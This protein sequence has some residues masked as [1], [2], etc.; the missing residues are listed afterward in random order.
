MDQIM[1]TTQTREEGRRL[2][3][4]L[5]QAFESGRA[6]FTKNDYKEAQLRSDFL[7]PFLKALGWDVENEAHASQFF[8]TVLQEESID[9]EEG[10]GDTRKKNPDY[11]LRVN[12]KRELFLE[13]KKARIDILTAKSPAFQTRRYGWSAGLRASVLTNFDQLV[14]YD[15]NYRPDAA[16]GAQV[17]RYQTF[18][19]TEYGDRF[20]EI[21]DILSYEAVTA[22][23]ITKVFEATDHERIGFDEFFLR[24]IQGWRHQLAQNILSNN[25]GLSTLQLN[26]LVQSLI[27]RIVFL[28]IC[29][30]REIEERDVL[31]NITSYEELKALF[32][33]SDKRYNSGLFDFVEDKISLGITIS[34]ETL[35]DIF[36]QLYFPNSP[37]DFAVVDSSILSQIYERFLSQKI[38]ILPEQGMVEIID[39]EQVVASN[40]VVPTP[41]FIVDEIV[42]TT[43]TPLVEGKSLEELRSLKIADICCG[44]GTF[45]IGAYN[46]LLRAYAHAA[47]EGGIND[48]AV[49]REDQF[50]TRHLTLN[51]KREIVLRNLWGVDF[52]RYAVEVARFSLLLK[53]LEDEEAASVDHFIATSKNKALPSLS[54]NIKSGNSLVGS[55]YYAF[56][57]RVLTD[58]ALLFKINPLEWADEFEFLAS[59]GGGFD[60]IIGN[61]PYVRIQNLQQFFGEEVRYYR[62]SKP[63]FITASE[64]NIDKYYLFIEKALQLIKAGGLLG[65]IVPNKFFV[66]TA[67]K[68][69][70]KYIRDNSSIADITHF[71]VTQVFAG[72]STYTAILVLQKS[73]RERFRFRRVNQE[74]ALSSILASP[75]IEYDN[76]G[77]GAD[78]WVFISEEAKAVFETV[79]NAGTAPLK[80]VAEVSVG[81]QTSADSIYILT[82]FTVEG[83]LT[84]FTQSGKDW[85]IETAILRDCFYD[86]SFGLF[87]KPV[88]NA[89]MIYPY[90]EDGGGMSVIQEDDLEAR[91][92]RCRAYLLSHKETLEKR[93][94]S[95]GKKD[96]QT[97]YQ[98]GR[99][100]SLGKFDD[101]EKLI[102]S[103]LAQEPPYGY[104]SHNV[105]FTGGGNGPYY[106]LISTS[107]YSIFYLLGIL[108]HPVIE[109]IVK[110]GASEFR[111][112]YYSH[113]KQFLKELPIKTINFDDPDEKAKH[114]AIRDV[115]QQ[116]VE[117]KQRI[118][119]THPANAALMRRQTHLHKRLLSLV[120]QLYGLSDQQTQ[121]IVDGG[122]FMVESADDD[123]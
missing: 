76:A 46:F 93:S 40:G 67:G 9:V 88:A 69:L 43:L 26:F 115:T 34:P 107:E 16:D 24:Q 37:Y 68:K 36:S 7:N 72:K 85:Q 80:E 30:D 65:Y 49:V 62:K 38:A 98:Y 83:E 97:W 123:E 23:S 44:S 35:I 114:D 119:E 6:A 14:I 95:G 94:I 74:K 25:P 63:G 102:W 96:L 12:G 120:N 33:Q 87:D 32:V 52:N 13:A 3:L 15:C 42:K 51:A 1:S 108:A 112:A 54:D 5:V 101:A 86:V 100:Q 22:G 121:S 28:R 77:F 105:L 57:E 19:Y 2:V 31:K 81:V 84:S 41:S 61:P 104:D 92:P 55:D 10:A 21:Y 50:G 73:D 18:S 48:P 117:G 78:P 109:A 79:Q 111:G 71:G 116:L 106:A 29:E 59:E 70:R 58:E 118:K 8:R 27:N 4:E 91:F 122:A 53:I 75:A 89:K 56:D 11:T 20:D 45:L 110:A 47:D 82:N 113:G 64:N 90:E 39:D 60:A 99:S 17:A 66:L 103:V